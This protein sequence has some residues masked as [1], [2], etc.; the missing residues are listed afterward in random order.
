MSKQFTTSLLIL[1]SGGHT[2]VGIFSHQQLMSLC[3]HWSRKSGGH[4]T[5]DHNLHYLEARGDFH[6]SSTQHVSS[7]SLHPGSTF[8]FSRLTPLCLMDGSPLIIS[9]WVTLFKPEGGLAVCPLLWVSPGSF[10][11]H[12][13]RNGTGSVAFCPFQCSCSIPYGQMELLPN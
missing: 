5:A 4:Q 13:Q 9:L 11:I 7:S 12:F 10:P 3:G 1:S 8:L 2:W 6:S